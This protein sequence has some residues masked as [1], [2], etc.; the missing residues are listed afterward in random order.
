MNKFIALF[1]FLISTSTIAYPVYDVVNCVKPDRSSFKAVVTF[2]L[3]AKSSGIILAKGVIIDGVAYNKAQY[4]QFYNNT[5]AA[6]G[7][8]VNS[9]WM[10][11]NYG[12]TATGRIDVANGPRPYN[13]QAKMVGSLIKNNFSGTIYFYNPG[14]KIVYS[15]SCK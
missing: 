3:A 13:S 11:T 5:L 15:V 4:N 14:D 8:N 6:S 10:P 7:V 2:D 9:N 1:L 12:L